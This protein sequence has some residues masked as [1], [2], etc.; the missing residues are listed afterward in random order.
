MSFNYSTFPHPQPSPPLALKNASPSP[1]NHSP[2]PIPSPP[3]S[4]PNA[5]LWVGP[6]THGPHHRRPIFSRHPYPN[7]CILNFQKVNRDRCACHPEKLLQG[8]CEVGARCEEVERRPTRQGGGG[9]K[10]EMEVGERGEAD[11][12]GRRERG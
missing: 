6:S 1:R 3:D 10:G 5:I 9:E 7:I 4:P 2:Q 8:R 12:D 11:G